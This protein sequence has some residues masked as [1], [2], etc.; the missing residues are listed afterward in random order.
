MGSGATGYGAAI[1]ERR[2]TEVDFRKGCARGKVAPALD[3]REP[4]A[5]RTVRKVERTIIAS[6][7]RDMC[8]I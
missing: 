7:K 4:F 8:L 1:G 3:Y 6:K 5:K 2:E